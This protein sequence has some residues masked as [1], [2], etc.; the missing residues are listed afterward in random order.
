M[1]EILTWACLGGARF[2]GKEDMLGSLAPGKR[3]GIVRI[4]DID[5]EGF[6]TPLSRSKRII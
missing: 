4:T 6:V 3:P 1:S 5:D 2:L